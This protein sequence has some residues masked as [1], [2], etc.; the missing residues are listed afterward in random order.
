MSQVED[1]ARLGL[2][3]KGMKNSAWQAP[4]QY[5][6]IGA[7]GCAVAMASLAAAPS[8]SGLFGAALG[9]LMLAIALADA[10]AFV[11]PDKLTL[12]AFVFGLVEAACK[13]FESI[14]ENI[15]GAAMRGAVLAFAFL[16]LR[17]AYWRLRHRQGIGLGDV[18]LAAVAGV[19]LDW[20][21][22]VAAIEIAALAALSTYTARQ[23]IRRR[24]LSQTAKLPFGLFFAPAIW[25]CWLINATVF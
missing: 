25:L 7:L 19:W 18:K 11:I 20:A 8:R 1:E 3:V 6:A 23:L 24:S 16:A 21:L 4:V 10:R 5:A 2:A 13:G 14:T 15:A 12:A 9:L 17:E 22:I